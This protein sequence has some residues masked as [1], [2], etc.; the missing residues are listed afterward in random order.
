MNKYYDLA[1]SYKDIAPS[2]EEFAKLKEKITNACRHY[3]LGRACIVKRKQ[4]KYLNKSYIN[5]V[6]EYGYSKSSLDKYVAFSKAIDLLEL[7]VPDVVYGIME[8]SVRLSMDNTIHVANKKPAEVLDIVSMLADKN[9]KISDVFYTQTPRK[10]IRPPRI[11]VTK[12][13]TT[14][15]DTPAYDPDANAQSLIY[16]IPSWVS[17]IDNAFMMQDFSAVSSKA[18]SKLKDVLISLSDTASAVVELLKETLP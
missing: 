2:P 4:A 16:T 6:K 9:V 7:S 5:P 1:M 18:R 11:P 8:G 15:K 17:A 14:I 13:P 12:K 3:I 10:R